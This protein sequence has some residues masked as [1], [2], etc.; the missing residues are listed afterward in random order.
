MKQL[1]CYLAIGAVFFL[2]GCYQRYQVYDL[3]E[4]EKHHI[5]PELVQDQ[6]YVQRVLVDTQTGKMYYFK[7]SQY[8]ETIEP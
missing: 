4:M 7:N 1:F 5:N 2:A 8:L 6:K 3:M